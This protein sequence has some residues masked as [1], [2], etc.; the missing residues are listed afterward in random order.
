MPA[1]VKEERSVKRTIF[2]PSCFQILNVAIHYVQAGELKPDRIKF[3]ADLRQKLRC[4]P[5]SG[6]TFQPFVR[7]RGCDRA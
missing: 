7:C 1:Y 3:K 6:G 5:S 2:W 4:D